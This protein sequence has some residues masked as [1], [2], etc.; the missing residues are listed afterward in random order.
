MEVLH[1]KEKIKVIIAEDFALLREDL[2]ETISTQYD[3]AV[4]GAAGNG[5]EILKLADSVEHDI[6][7]MDIEMESV[8]A[9]IRAAE[10]IRDKNKEE[11]IIYLTAHETKEMI[12][13]AMGTGAV[14]YI[15]KGAPEEKIVSRIRDAYEGKTVLEGRVKELVLQEYKRLQESEKSLLFFVN[16]LSNLTKTERELIRLLLDNNKVKKIAEIRGVELATIKSQINTLLKKLGASRTKEITK[17]IKNL[18]LTHLF[19]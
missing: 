3:M 5:V 10:A 9:G 7:L 2:V 8:Y 12:L 6:I 14:D 15:V 17:T 18:N 19:E 11:K 4:M 1:V 16:N 13:T